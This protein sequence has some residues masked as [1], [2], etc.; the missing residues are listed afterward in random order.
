[1]ERVI[2][3]LLLFSLY[4]VGWD[5][6][7]NSTEE[8]FF[9]SGPFLIC[10]KR[11]PILFETRTAVTVFN[12]VRKWTW[13]SQM[14]R[15]LILTKDILSSGPTYQ[16][17]CLR[18]N[19]SGL[20]SIYAGFEFRSLYFFSTSKPILWQNLETEHDPSRKYLFAL[21]CHYHP[22]GVLKQF[23]NKLQKFS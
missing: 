3:V 2:V 16:A 22:D 8:C 20:Y 12:R 23:I 19:A 15:D 7:D 17:L 11:P 5:N 4:F 13:A 9:K 18:G 10:S 14:N 21:I 6:G 1:M